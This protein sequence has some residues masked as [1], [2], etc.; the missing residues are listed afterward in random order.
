MDGI[1]AMDEQQIVLFNRTAEA[2]FGW[3]AGQVLGRPIE[4]L[5]PQRFHARHHE[6][7]RQ[8]GQVI[9]ANRRMGSQ[10]TVAALR[11]N[12]EEFP[13]EASISQYTSMTGRS[14]W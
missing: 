11:S 9:T 13:I 10:R 4:M 5:I 8:C 1:I 3:N 12:G 14:T 7:V 2:I 6:D